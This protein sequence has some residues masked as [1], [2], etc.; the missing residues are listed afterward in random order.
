L[1]DGIAKPNIKTKI[2]ARGFSPSFVHSEEL[3]L[4]WSQSVTQT[5]L[6]LYTDDITMPHCTQTDAQFVSEQEEYSFIQDIIQY[7]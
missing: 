4:M 3:L 7:T 1:G 2:T 6:L 5:T